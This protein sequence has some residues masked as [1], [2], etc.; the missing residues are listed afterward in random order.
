MEVTLKNGRKIWQAIPENIE[1]K[2][3]YLSTNSPVVRLGLVI[4]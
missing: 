3:V 1:I 4:K 2:G